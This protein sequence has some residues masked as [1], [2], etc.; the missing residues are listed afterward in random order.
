MSKFSLIFLLVFFG[1]ILG[2]LFIWPVFSVLVYQIVYFVNPDI[3]WWSTSIPGLPYSFITS[4][5]II[6]VL[7]VNYRKLTDLSPWREQPVLKWL[8]A[9]LTIYFLINIIALV[10][11][12]HMTFTIEFLKLVVIIFAS[13]KL[14]NTEKSLDA[15]LWVYVFGATYIG[16]LAYSTG[17]GS[18][19]RVEDIGMIDT[20]GDSNMTAAAL[21]PALVILTY[22]AWMGN[23]KIK[24]LAV[25]CGAFIANGVVLINS[26]GAFLGAVTGGLFFIFYMLFSK[27][28]RTGQRGAAIFIIILGLAGAIYVAD[29]SFWERMQTLKSVDDGSKSG[30]HRVEFWLA[31][32]DIMEDY[33]LG[34]GIQGY[35]ELSPGYLPGHYFERRTTGKAVHSSWFQVLS[36]VGW[37]GLFILIAMLVSIAK[38]S[39]RAKKF[40]VNQENFDAYFKLLAL[41]GALLSFLVA[42]SFID[43]GRA[44]MLYWLVLFV[45]VAVNIY[46]LQ[47]NRS[48]ADSGLSSRQMTKPKR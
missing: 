4:M 27:Y 37:V 18:T 2:A 45:L 24:L 48:A 44:V 32:F 8:L 47:P 13:Y 28:Q 26:R 34:V 46:Y 7:L 15:C 29:D 12:A 25:I 19:G 22:M 43:R 41:E 38:Q 10:P 1:G 14:V 23:K 31:T 11:D 6:F 5:T 16:Y 17:R 30:S 35:V 21:V 39:S 20:G 3:R 33:P 42:A 40:L 36:E 9:L